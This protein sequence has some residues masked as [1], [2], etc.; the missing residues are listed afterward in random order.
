M[1][2]AELRAKIPV[3][4]NSFNQPTFLR[5]MVDWHSANGFKSITV[6]DNGSLS[7]TLLDY[8]DSAAFTRRAT[9]VQ[10][11]RNIGPRG[12]VAGVAR[13]LGPYNAFIFSDPDLWLPEKPA[14]DFLTHMF[15]MGR[16]Y[17]RAKVGL[18]LDIAQPEL[19]RDITMVTGRRGKEWTI[20]RWEKRFWKFPLQ[21][22]VYDAQVDTTYFLHVP[23]SGAE[24]NLVD[25]GQKQTR[26][27]SLRIAG[28]GFTARHRPWYKDDGQPD[29]E[30]EF[31]TRSATHVSTWTRLER[32]SAGDSE[33]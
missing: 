9:L 3:F 33:D 1:T 22:N 32:K 10:Q 27:P 12:T 16:K 31:Y 30:R 28:E 7:K 14:P 20:T 21:Q 26:V 5:E 29:A 11:N 24:R 18:A 23:N 8:F 6:M 2:E 13:E 19:F 4:I 17:R 15:D 25:F